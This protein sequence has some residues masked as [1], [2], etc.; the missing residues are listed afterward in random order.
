VRSGTVFGAGAEKEKE[1]KGKKRWALLRLHSYSNYH[2]RY[3][4]GRIS[5]SLPSTALVGWVV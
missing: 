3:E 1:N 2:G 4:T 5:L